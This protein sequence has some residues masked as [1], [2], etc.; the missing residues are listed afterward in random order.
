MNTKRW[1]FYLS[2]RI[3]SKADELLGVAVAGIESDY[4]SNLFRMISLGEDS[5]VSLFRLDGALLATTWTRPIYW[6]RPTP[7][8]SR[9]A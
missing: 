4:F 5:S 9:S 1:N 3:K 2:R 6:A 7:T 8:L